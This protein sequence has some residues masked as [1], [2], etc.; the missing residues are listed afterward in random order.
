MAN[1]PKIAVFKF[2]GCAGCQMELLRMVDEFPELLDRVEISYFKM[3]KRDN[4]LGPY[5]I[6]LIEGSVSTPRE[7][8]EIKE[9]RKN[10]KMVVAM[11]DCAVT[12]CV[13]SIRNW[14]P[15]HES[16]EL[17]YEDTLVI[18]SFRPLGIGEYLKVDYD[19][20]GCPP[21]KNLILGFLIKS[22][23][24]LRVYHR[25][26]SVCVECKLKENVCLL[27]SLMQPCMGPVTR[28][29]CDAICPS[30]G[31]VCEG[32]YG[33]MNDANPEFLAESFKECGLNDDD[34]SRKFRK[35]AGLTK[36]FF[37]EASKL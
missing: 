25:P 29:G 26:H 2:T 22:L 5:D 4:L 8:K 34:I 21:D 10:S 35:Y 30:G 36:E 37:K 32:C 16:E 33:P 7:L 23:Q 13:P 6:S 3:A 12:G 11:G 15:Q 18:G 14:I 19:I 31:R 27:T 20:P 24:E 1:K 17:V 9:I 28:A